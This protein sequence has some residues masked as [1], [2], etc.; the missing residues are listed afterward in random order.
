M[1][2]HCC[3]DLAVA[4]T[5]GDALPYART[6]LNV[7]AHGA[8]LRQNSTRPD[9]ALAFTGKSSRRE[10]GGF[11]ARIQ[12]LFGTQVGVGTYREG[13]A[14]ACILFGVVFLGVALSGQTQGNSWKPEGRAIGVGVAD[15][16]EPVLVYRASPEL[17]RALEGIEAESVV[18]RAADMGEPGAATATRVYRATPALKRA[19]RGLDDELLGLDGLDGLDALDASD[20]VV[21]RVL[22]E[23]APPAPPPPP[24]PAAPSVPPATAAPPAPAAAPAPDAP[25]APAAPMPPTAPVAPAP[26]PEAFGALFEAI[27]EGDVGAVEELL[28]EY[29]MLGWTQVSRDGFTPLLLAA[30]NGEEEIA[31]LLAR[32]TAAQ[33]LDAVEREAAAAEYERTFSEA[34]LERAERL[35]ERAEHEV[36]QRQRQREGQV[37]RRAEAEA[38]RDRVREEARAAREEAELHRERARAAA[39]E[40]RPQHDQH[41]HVD[42]D[43]HYDD[44]GESLGYDPPAGWTALIEAADEGELATVRR[45]VDGGAALNTNTHAGGI[46]ALTIAAGN[47]HGDVVAYLIEAGARVNG[48]GGGLPP[49]HSAAEEGQLDVA[50]ILLEAGAE[51]DLRDYSGRTALMYAADEGNAEVA[52]WLLSE[53]A[54]AG[55]TD[56]QGYTALDYAADEGHADL[57]R[58]LLAFA[59][60]GDAPPTGEALGPALRAAAD[61]GHGD[62]VRVLLEAGADPAG[63]DARGRTALDYAAAE[64]HDD[65]VRL[66]AAGAGSVAA[67]P[68]ALAD[69]L[70]AAASEGH[71]PVVRDLLA[72]GA[73]IDAAGPDGRTALMQAAGERHPRVLA[74]LLEAGADV[75]VADARGWTALHYAAGERAHR[76]IELLVEAGASVDAR[77]DYHTVTRR[78]GPQAVLLAYRGATPLVVALEEDDDGAA[79]RL[80]RAGADANVTL[81]KL[82][83][84]TLADADLHAVDALAQALLNGDDVGGSLAI[85]YDEAGWTPLHE[86]AERGRLEALRMLLA[87]GG[88]LDRAAS[89]GPDPRMIAEEYG[90]PAVVEFI[91]GVRGGRTD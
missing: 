53:G 73:D 50:R 24:A 18:I 20:L 72:A 66:L 83:A 89:A 12:R 67:S 71:A 15:T 56:N 21:V 1:R 64:G 33:A 17:R 46:D 79:E 78:L 63:T 81:R 91:D 65:L 41:V 13:F 19:L 30:R 25:A 86:A 75:A 45:L 23:S 34:E 16:G 39:R 74:A 7:S 52:G 44:A 77:A 58:A 37:E 27:D 80:L 28:R 5:D 8:G 2:E 70:R 84:T 31:T 55:L 49:L 59:G 42:H 40:P 87:F 14:T 35:R 61:E 88:D 48:T 32:A 36:E 9:L 57:V 38:Q 43:V 69:A 47:G 62:V 22:G 76:C 11:A 60:E 51:L 26:P 6:L 90:N 3:D 85:A 82:R 54:D 4:A 10:R 29:P 68:P